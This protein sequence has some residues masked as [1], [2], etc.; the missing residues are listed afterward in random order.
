MN[1]KTNG[2]SI[3]N[4]N[5]KLFACTEIEVIEF[6]L[7]DYVTVRSN[8][9]YIM[10]N[11]TMTNEPKVII[12][13]SDIYSLIDHP[14]SYPANQNAV[15]G[16]VYIAVK[17]SDYTN[18]PATFSCVYG[19]SSSNLQIFEKIGKTSFEPEAYIYPN[20]NDKSINLGVYS[21]YIYLDSNVKYTVIAMS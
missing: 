6:S 14:I 15:L 1:G 7:N 10:C 16:G 13:K 18:L 21:S 11:Y 20:A 12:L 4:L 8:S 5:P 3:G 2:M 17:E 9:S 19:Y